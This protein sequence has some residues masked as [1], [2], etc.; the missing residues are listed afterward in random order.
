MSNETPT[1]AVAIRNPKDLLTYLQ[2]SQSAID[3]ALPSHLKSARM[4]R[5]ALTCFSTNPELRKCT[6]QSI[7]A[8]VVVASQLGLEPG[9]AGQGY[10]IPYKGQCTFVPGWQGLVSL[11]NNTGRATAWTGAVYEGDDFLFQLGSHPRCEHTPGPNY[12][13]P[14]LLRWV[15]AVGRVNGSEHP[16]IEAWPMSR[17]WKHRD[18]YNK[19]GARHYSYAQPEMYSRKCV[20]LQVLKYMPRSIELNN[21]ITASDAAEL[22]QAARVEDSVVVIDHEPGDIPQQKPTF[23][24]TK[25]PKPQTQTIQIEPPTTEPFIPEPDPNNPPMDPGIADAIAAQISEKA[26]VSPAQF[27]SEQIKASAAAAGLPEAAVAR[28]VAAEKKSVRAKAG[29]VQEPPGP[30][31]MLIA[32]GVVFDDFTDWM[33]NTARNTGAKDWGSYDDVPSSVWKGLE[34]D[35]IGVSKCVILYGKTAIEPAQ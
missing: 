9:I 2:R 19:V 3:M 16:V 35:T 1:G 6:P 31:E 27:L 12:G 32:A 13:D 24:T 26:Q 18:R 20:L 34:K 15:Y 21:A 29:P 10:L 23:E 4:I 11:L 25:W 30:K 28:Q 8:S 22:G 14:D 17:V 5:L 7:L 33:V